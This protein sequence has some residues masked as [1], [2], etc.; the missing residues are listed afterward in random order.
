MECK[1]RFAVIGTG[2]FAEECQ[3]PGRTA[4]SAN[5]SMF[6]FKQMVGARCNHRQRQ[7]GVTKKTFLVGAFLVI[8]VHTFL[9]RFGGYAAILYQF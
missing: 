1:L 5:R 3:I 6:V 9:M 8:W 2:R 7:H 4:R